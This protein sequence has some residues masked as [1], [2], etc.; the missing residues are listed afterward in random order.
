VTF[1]GMRRLLAS[2]ATRLLCF[3]SC[4]KVLLPGA[5]YLLG[6]EHAVEARGCHVMKLGFCLQAGRA[7]ECPIVKD[8]TCDQRG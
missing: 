2:P 1:W 6:T 8:R 4:C 5:L 3:F 7:L